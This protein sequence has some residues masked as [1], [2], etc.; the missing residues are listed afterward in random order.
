M[1]KVKITVVKRLNFNEIHGDM[2][3]GCSAKM[4]PVCKIFKE[5]QEFITDMATVPEGFCPGGFCGYFPFYQRTEV[6]SKLSVDE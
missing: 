3:V 6:W 1:V 2:D 5:G 4:D